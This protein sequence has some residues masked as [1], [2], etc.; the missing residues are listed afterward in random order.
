MIGG[1]AITLQDHYVLV[2][3]RGFALTKHTIIERNF[4]LMAAR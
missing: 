3:L 1:Q 4:V 2:V